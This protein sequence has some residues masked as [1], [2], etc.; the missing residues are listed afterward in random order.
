MSTDHPSKVAD[1]IET[2]FKSKKYT[3]LKIGI[4][5]D[6]NVR[7]GKYSKG[8]VMFPIFRGNKIRCG[9]FEDA[10]I[11]M[12]TD[13]LDYKKVSNKKEDKDIST[14]NNW[15]NGYTYVVF[16][17]QGRLQRCKEEQE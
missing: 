9:R 1:W 7:K 11:T 5:N 15:S 6:V 3:S 4:T 16:S 2:H 14:R 17:K 12:M 10:M 13:R 8:D